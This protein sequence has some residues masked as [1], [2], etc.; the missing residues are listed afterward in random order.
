MAFVCIAA[1]GLVLA[2]G[3]VVAALRPLPTWD[4]LPYMD[5]VLLSEGRTPQQAHAFAYS[6]IARARDAALYRGDSYLTALARSADLFDEELPFYAIRPGY[7]FLI[8]LAH[9]RGLGLLTSARLVSIA[10]Y[11]GLGILL[12]AWMLRYAG[13][14]A[15]LAWA[16]VVMLSGVT[17]SLAR[18]VTPDAVSTLF[19]LGGVYAVTERRALP[20]GLLILLGSLFIRTD[21]VLFVLAVLC[22]LAF[23]RELKPYQA[24]VLALLACAV[25]AAIDWFSGNYGWRV[26]FEASFV[27]P[28]PIGGGTVAGITAGEYLA[29]FARNARELAGTYLPLVALLGAAAIAANPRHRACTALAVLGSATVVRFLL[30]PTTQLRGYAPATLL[31]MLA[32]FAVLVA[33]GGLRKTAGE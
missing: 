6:E 27:L 23:S 2:F 10:G 9:R 7:L 4:A 5:L 14:A 30:Y 16:A 20:T 31:S 17:L 28:F 11:A 29:V 33:K 24:A 26:L 1:Y 25:V 19:V 18:I 22:W 13:M 15:S 32:V 3:S 21:N 8:R 12:F